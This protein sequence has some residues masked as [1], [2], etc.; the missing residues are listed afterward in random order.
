MITQLARW[1]NSLALRIPNAFVRETRIGEGQSVDIA[2]ID[3]KI[4]IAP[5]ESP[6][7]FDL[8]TLLSDIS[9]ENIPHEIDFTEAAPIGKEIW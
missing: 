5:V 4:V 3:G 8:Q 9:P 6:T 2:V 1:G 7:V